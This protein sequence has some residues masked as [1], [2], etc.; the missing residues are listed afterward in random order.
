MIREEWA[1]SDL[2]PTMMTGKTDLQ[3]AALIVMIVRTESTMTGKLL[4]WTALAP[5]GSCCK[6]M[7]T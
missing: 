3:E 1:N 2:A 4:N 6:T 7:R 5:F